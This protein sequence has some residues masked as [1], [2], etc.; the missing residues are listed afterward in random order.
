MDPSM[1]WSFAVFFVVMLGVL[2][3]VNHRAYRWAT[4]AFSLPPRAKQVLAGVLIASL[5][6]M[7][8]GRVLD[9][10]AAGQASRLVLFSASVV[11]LAVLISVALLLV[12]DLGVLG[13]GLTRRLAALRA[14][15][16]KPDTGTSAPAS[17]PLPAE[18]EAVAVP[19]RAV[20]AQMAA[21]SAF[22]IGG[23][24]S[25]YGTLVGRHDYTIEELAV[26]LPGLSKAL[27][28]F[29]IVQLSDIHV[30]SFVGDAELE[31]GFEFVKRARPDLVVL[32]GDLIDHDP[33]VAERLGR[34]ARRLVPLAREGVTAITG[35]HDF[36][37]GV[38]ETVGALER[39]GARVLRNEGR[40]IGGA[41]GFALLGVDDVWAKRFNPGA[42]PDLA[43]ALSSLPE[44]EGRHVAR[45]LPRV[46][47]CHNPSYFEESAGHV[48]LQVSGHTHGGQV[49]LVVRP[50]ELFLKNGW[51]AGLYERNGSKLYVNRGFGTAGPPA[52]VGS[53]PE[54]TRIVLASA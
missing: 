32:T 49:N 20:L 33:R 22:L 2:S 23:S 10:L 18:A 43:Q 17:N 42:G 54:I 11:Q 8:L 27:D 1:T 36:Y 16:A 47:L 50:G 24:S 3:W 46:L 40:V 6:G 48:D 29:T 13:A 19:R 4:R 31:A 21:G 14:K 39:A 26:R 5:A 25:L 9:R 38:D 41:R 44:V 52:R 34:F 37:A 30:G 45:D 53:P 35:N 15:P 51:I 28:G 7:T 12:V